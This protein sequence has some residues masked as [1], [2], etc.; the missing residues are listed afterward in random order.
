[1][2]SRAVIFG[3]KGPELSPE[4]AAFFR[5][6]GPWGFIL[7]ARNIECPEQLRRLTDDLRKAVGRDAPV[8]IDQEGGRVARMRAPHWREWLPALDQC[9][10]I[11][12]D[13]FRIRS[14][15]LR[16]RLMAG[17]L[18]NVGIDVNCAPVLDLV[19]PQTHAAIRN[20]CYGSVPADVASAGRAVAEGLL[21]GGVLPIMKHIP[22]QGRAS[23]DSHLDLPVV[24]R[25][26]NDLLESDF[27]PFQAL[28]HLPM[29]MTSHVVFE[30]L[31]PDAPATQSRN[32]INLIR[33]EIGFDGLLLTD[34]LSMHAL[35]GGFAERARRSLSAG[36]DVVLHCNGD[37]NEM[38]AVLERVP[39]LCG[40]PLS[41][42]EAALALRCGSDD[43]DIAAAE[44]ELADL[45]G[46]GANA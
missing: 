16:S 26:L 17:E 40:K 7:F 36:C 41:R 32:V 42:A 35:K 29:A 15:Y 43:M 5:T 14:M 10:R 24:S 27:A 13:T 4:E 25:A 20:R 33:S 28:S 22:G 34:D 2:G 19:W 38:S 6:V 12:D 8:L 23:L 31:D 21:A 18:S 45:L 37:A 46:E 3:C 1:M 30:G 44:A 39:E 9:N 11:F